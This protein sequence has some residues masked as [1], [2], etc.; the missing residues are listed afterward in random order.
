MPARKPRKP[1]PTPEPEAQPTPKPKPSRGRGRVTRDR[2]TWTTAQVTDSM[3]AVDLVLD[4]TRLA[5]IRVTARRPDDLMVADIVLR[6]MQIVTGTSPTLRRRDPARDATLVLQLAPQSFGEECFLDS[7]GPEVRSKDEAKH[8]EDLDDSNAEAGDGKQ[9][10][11]SDA[12]QVV[13]PRMARIRMSGHSRLAFTMPASV[14]SIPFTLEAILQACRTWP[15]RRAL[16]AQAASF[17]LGM[18]SIAGDI[19]FLRGVVASGEFDSM[20]RTLD[21]TLTDLGASDLSQAVASAG[22]AVAGV[23][24]TVGERGTAAVQKRVDSEV[25]AIIARYPSLGTDAQARSLVAVRI[26]LEASRMLTVDPSLPGA[27]KPEAGVTVLPPML[28]PHRPAHDVT[29]IEMPYRLVISPVGETTWRHRTTAEA[30]QGRHEVWHTRLVDAG[31]MGSRDGSTQLRAIWS[32]DYDRGDLAELVNDMKPFRMPLD[33]LDRDWLVRLTSGFRET[34]RD[35]QRFTPKPVSSRR[36]I[37]SALGGLLDTRGAWND[38]PGDVDLEQWQHRMSLGRDHYVRVVYSGFL[39]PFGHAASLIKVTERK[40]EPDE[41]AAPLTKRVA[42]LRQRFFIVVRE[43]VMTFNGSRH[44]SGGHAF[45]FTSIELQTLITPKLL[46]PDNPACRVVD[47]DGLLYASGGLAH[48]E[49]FWPMVGEGTDNFRFTI[50]AIDRD[51]KRTTFAMPLLFVAGRANSLT[52]TKGTQTT[53]FIDALRRG[54]NAETDLRRGA[55]LG[56]ASVCYAPPAADAA[57]DPRLPTQNLLFRAARVSS[58]STSALNAYPEV[59]DAFVA[60]RAVQRILGRDDAMVHVR[61][62]EIYA[63]KGFGEGNAGE[64]FLKLTDANP[65]WDINFGPSANASRTDAVGAIASP[66][67]KITG[68]SRRIG[69]ASD[70]DAVQAN[71]FEPATFFADAR[72]LGG[73]RLR[74]VI[75]RV[76]TGLEG[77]AVPKFVT[78]DLP[79]S[80]GQ[81][82]RTEAR[83]DWTT[84]L[85]KPDL[86]GILIPRAASGAPSPFIMSAV[87]TALA[88]KPASASSVITATI[89]NFSVSMFG[90][91][92]LRF[93]RLRY[94]T[95]DGQKPDVTV[96]MHPVDAVRFGGPLNFVNK[97]REFIPSDGFS[98]PSAIKVTPSGISAAYSLSVPHAEVGAFALSGLSIGAAFNLPFD[99]QPMSVAFS[100]GKREDPFSLTI[101]LCGG[102]GFLVIGVGTDGVRE[103]EAAIEAQARLSIDLGVASGSVE[104]SL[105][106]YFHWLPGPNSDG[107]VELSGYVRVHGELTV[108]CAISISLTFN[109]QLGIGK[110]GNDLIVFGEA[111]VIVEVEVLVFSGEVTVRCRRE[112]TSPEADPTFAQLVTGLPTWESYCLAFAAE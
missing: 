66:S 2:D 107:L 50:A 13:P 108:M 90:F 38:R 62:D 40:F 70:L 29:A 36:L 24:A 64:V 46:A 41:K 67:M 111:S 105:G 59:A 14:S 26:G 74:D 34:R 110:R 106:I 8:Y 16:T 10:F 28:A 68:L 75:A 86:K 93:D 35:G 72:I 96:E 83:Y 27:F 51:G 5:P 25:A 1:S 89:G 58:D 92:V 37:L 71:T 6:N 85:G 78:R 87:T 22:K 53:K 48:R 101:S 76:T 63:S 19:A 43:P 69:I 65:S 42:R 104:I 73:I 80:G 61:Y 109:L 84:T 47:A 57:G 20:R 21:A 94:Q 97:L 81:P 18:Q 99:S 60:L 11:E 103:I 52:V 54:Y 30:R 102:G 7:T 17:G 95:T 15:L 44:W 32:D 77:D 56:G 100:F 33:P 49:A 112:F 3:R 39:M 98:D 79:A 23:I 88:G 9:S 55:D 4:S 31:I 45:P 82:A 12:E 91:I